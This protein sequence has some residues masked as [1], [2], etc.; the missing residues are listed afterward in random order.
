MC[1]HSM[2]LCFAPSSKPPPGALACP[3][4]KA[5]ICREGHNYNQSYGKATSETC[6]NFSLQ[7]PTAEQHVSPPIKTP[8]LS[9]LYSRFCHIV[10]EGILWASANNHP[11]CTQHA[12]NTAGSMMFVPCSALFVDG[13]FM[14]CMLSGHR[15]HFACRKT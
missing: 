5:R 8:Q 15:P 4:R 13:I 6:R 10:E 11:T 3:P 7:C 2:L 14:A 9:T 1:T 12:A